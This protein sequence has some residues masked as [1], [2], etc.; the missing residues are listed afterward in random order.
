MNNPQSVLGTNSLHV[1]VENTEYTRIEWTGWEG[2]VFLVD[3]FNLCNKI[4]LRDLEVLLSNTICGYN[5]IMC[6]EDG[7][8]SMEDT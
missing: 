1:N 4:I 2:C 3:L 5:L 8:E 7:I 6:Y